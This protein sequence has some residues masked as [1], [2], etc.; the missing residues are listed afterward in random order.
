MAICCVIRL[1]CGELKQPPPVFNAV[2][3]SHSFH[4]FISLFFIEIWMFCMMVLFRNIL[5][6]HLEDQGS[7]IK[8]CIDI[9]DILLFLRYLII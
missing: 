9:L 4:S 2:A 5:V 7:K 1:L 6:L 8:F 3:F